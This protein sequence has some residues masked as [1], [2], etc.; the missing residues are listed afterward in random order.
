MGIASCLETGVSLSRAIWIYFTRAFETTEILP[1]LARF[2]SLSTINWNSICFF[3]RAG[4]WTVLRR[5]KR[6]PLAVPRCERKNS[7][8][9]TLRSF[10]RWNKSKNGF[11]NYQL[12]DR[13]AKK[14]DDRPFGVLSYIV[15]Q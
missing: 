9:R 10:L 1:I 11:F 15:L 2:M 13:T 3:K 7:A 5:I 12:D 6:L 14:L 4:G 8:E